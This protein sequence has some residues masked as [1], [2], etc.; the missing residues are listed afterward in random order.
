MEKETR[1]QI[2]WDEHDQM[3]SPLERH[4][5]PWQIYQGRV[6][7]PRLVWAEMTKGT[8]TETRVDCGW[9]ERHK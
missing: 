5:G 3:W 8:H 2:M 6:A 1:K 4:V 9:V 7:K